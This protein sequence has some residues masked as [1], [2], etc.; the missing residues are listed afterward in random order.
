[1][2]SVVDEINLF[3]ISEVVDML[4]NSC[5]IVYFSVPVLITVI[6]SVLVSVRQNTYRCP[7]PEN[8][9]SI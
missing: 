2:V 9:I 6:T 8:I 4:V 7:D 3:S 1:M 5:V